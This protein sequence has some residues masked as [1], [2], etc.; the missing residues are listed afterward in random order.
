MLVFFVACGVTLV[1]LFI[2]FLACYAF[3]REDLSCL[4]ST[5]LTFS[6]FLKLYQAN[7]SLWDF[8][9]F[10][11]KYKDFFIDFSLIDHIRYRFWI[12]RKE[13][14]EAKKQKLNNTENF[15]KAYRQDLVRQQEAEIKQL[16]E[17]I[18]HLSQ[19][20]SL[21]LAKTPEPVEDTREKF[22]IKYI[23]ELPE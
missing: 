3:D 2:T 12:F 6:S 18:K 23:G 1:I 21:T 9:F 22:I 17:K 8:S 20:P 11:A 5:R 16:E 15:I 14:R 19:S 13:K 4:S 10:T 7:P